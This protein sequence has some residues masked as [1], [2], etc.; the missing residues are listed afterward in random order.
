MSTFAVNDFSSTISN[1]DP[2]SAVS[3]DGYFS[4]G[5]NSSFLFPIAN[6]G[7]L[8]AVSSSSLLYAVIGG[9]LSILTGSLFWTNILPL[10]FRLAISFYTS[11][12]S[13]ASLPTLFIC[14]FCNSIY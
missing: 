6:D 13:L 14:S 5:A 4:L 7:S 3:S 12:C 9:L 11:H 10:L 1:D 8:F 2:L